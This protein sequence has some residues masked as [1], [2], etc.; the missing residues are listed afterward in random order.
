M[1]DNGR[2]IVCYCTNATKMNLP[3]IFIHKDFTLF[4]FNPLPPFNHLYSY[5]RSTGSQ[6]I[7]FFPCKIKTGRF[8]FR[9]Y[10]KPTALTPAG[11]NNDVYWQGL[12]SRVCS[13][14]IHFFTFLFP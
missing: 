10:Q 7:I 11:S 12:A 5:Q 6:I 14:I 4:S 13:D 1:D 8:L 9:R 3:R 2:C